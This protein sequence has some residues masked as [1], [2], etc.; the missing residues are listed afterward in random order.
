M[1]KRKKKA[2]KTVLAKRRL[3]LLRL[4]LAFPYCHYCGIK[5]ILHKDMKKYSTGYENWHRL[6]TLDHKIA[7][8]NGGKDEDSNYVLACHRCNNEKSNKFTYRAF[9]TLKR[10]K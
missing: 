1:V 3:A 7:Q 9:L 2:S 4:Y 5:T 8:A 10:T 6:A